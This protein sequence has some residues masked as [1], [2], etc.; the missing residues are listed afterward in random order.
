M[1]SKIGQFFQAAPLFLTI[2]ALGL[3]SCATKPDR[4]RPP[5]GD[6]RLDRSARSSGTFIQPAALLFA[7]MDKNGDRVTTRAELIS[8]VQA[9]W[10]SFDRSPSAMS[11]VT[12][13]KT[14]LGSTDAN[15]TFMSFDRD[16]NGVISK[17]EFTAQFE[18]LFKSLDKNGDGAV[19]RSEMIVAFAAPQGRSKPGDERGQRGERGGRG[20]G[21]P[22]RQ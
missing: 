1:T 6:D 8:G 11:F 9:E 17:S 15:P 3:T 16:F 22:S 10:D 2:T 21:R 7:D 18:S 13:S 5:R 19:E 4:D 20:G 14:A 12:W